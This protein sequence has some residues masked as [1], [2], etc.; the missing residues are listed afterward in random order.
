MGAWKSHKEVH[1]GGVRKRH[2]QRSF[3]LWSGGGDAGPNRG[4][5]KRALHIHVTTLHNN[6]LAYFWCWEKAD[7]T[8]G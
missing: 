6:L 2:K 8:V 3:Q 5:Q 4:V 1:A 7:T